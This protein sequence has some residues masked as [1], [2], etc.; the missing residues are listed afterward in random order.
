MAQNRPP[1]S[2][3]TS[4]P[5]NPQLHPSMMQRLSMGSQRSAASSIGSTRASTSLLEGPPMKTLYDASQ[6]QD[7][8]SMKSRFK[9]CALDQDREEMWSRIDRMY[10]GGQSK[11]LHLPLPTVVEARSC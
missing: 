8:K 5:L 4:S 9:C 6:L 7:P 10:Y 3:P 2:Q 1:T 11:P